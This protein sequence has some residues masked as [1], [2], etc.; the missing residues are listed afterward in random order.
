MVVSAV[1]SA[2]STPPSSAPPKAEGLETSAVAPASDGSQQNARYFSPF[3]QFDHELGLAIIQ[4]R[5]ANT[6]AVIRQV[7]SKQ[8][9]DEYRARSS[10][11]SLSG[12][13]ISDRTPGG[14]LG[15]PA[16]SASSA[17]GA[18]VGPNGSAGA[19]DPA[20]TGSNQTISADTPTG[21]GAGERSLL[22]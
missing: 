17:S 20:A 14:S 4:Y 19:S 13:E 21:G 9:V 2:R 22:A 12:P 15:S 3:I 1:D 16:S 5:D 7:P 18:S 10:G 6:G 8:A 11:T